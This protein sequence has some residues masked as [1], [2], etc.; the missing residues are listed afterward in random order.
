MKIQIWQQW[1]SNHSARFTV[2]GQFKTPTEA[3]QA[4]AVLRQDLRRIHNWHI[5]HD[6]ERYGHI[7][8]DL[9]PVELELAEK[10]GVEWAALAVDWAYFDDE[11]GF[12]P[13]SVFQ[14][15]VFIDGT[16]SD[17]GAHP[18]DKLIQKLGGDA[19]VQ[20]T[21]GLSFDGIGYS[22][23]GYASPIHFSLRCR[24]ESV[25]AA[26][27]ARDHVREVIQ[28][29]LDP[30]GESTEPIEIR[31]AIVHIRGR[32]YTPGFDIQYLFDELAALGCQDIEINLE[33]EQT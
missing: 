6:G 18:A 22:S 32:I 12:E 11:H 31:D 24:A 8:G 7:S 19:Y 3:Q 9:T 28:P 10:Y 16:N 23:S 13:V 5:E 25:E 15:W 21:L 30:R 27:H 17:I 29:I 4:A 14:N 1:S 20:G 33:Q 26:Q 2:I